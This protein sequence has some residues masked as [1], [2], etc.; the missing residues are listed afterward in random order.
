MFGVSAKQCRDHP[1]KG[2]PPTN[3]EFLPKALRNPKVKFAKSRS[4]FGDY[5]KWSDITTVLLE[6]VFGVSAKQVCK[7][8]KSIL[9]LH[10]MFLHDESTAGK[11][12]C[13]R[14]EYLGG[15]VGGGG[16]TTTTTT[17]ATTTTTSTTTT[18]TTTTTAHPYRLP[19]PL[20]KN[21]VLT[22]SHGTCSSFVKCSFKLA[23]LSVLRR[24]GNICYKSVA[25]RPKP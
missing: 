5:I 7:L 16:P 4:R 15:V 19:A 13:V 17:T 20:L 14:E 24:R 10:K 18:T 21:C 1:E 2:F 25:K 6:I 9:R 11:K 23:T 22:A 8:D 3:V 12:G